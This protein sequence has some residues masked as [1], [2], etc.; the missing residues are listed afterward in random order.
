[1]S[2]LKNQKHVSKSSLFPINFDSSMT[3]NIGEFLPTGIFELTPHSH[4]R[5]SIKSGARLAPMVNPTFGKCSVYD[6]V[7]NFKLNDIYPLYNDIIAQNPIVSNSGSSFVPS[8]VPSFYLSELYCN[9]LCY[10][11]YAIYAKTQYGD[12]LPLHSEFYNYLNG[13]QST[14]YMQDKAKFISDFIFHTL[15]DSM[16]DKTIHQVGTKLNGYNTTPNVNTAFTTLVDAYGCPPAS[17]FYQ[18]INGVTLGT[19]DTKTNVN[20]ENADYSIYVSDIYCGNAS[21]YESGDSN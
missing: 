21:Q 16:P 14:P 12:I 11:E 19:Y 4:V 13:A 8:S 9:L 7:V 3:T 17:E 2:K 10:S 18:N 15:M 6:Y 1:M 20:I 5:G